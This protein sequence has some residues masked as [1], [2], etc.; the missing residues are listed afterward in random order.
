MSRVKDNKAVRI[1]IAET[2]NEC[3]AIAAENNEKFTQTVQSVTFAILQ[4]ISISLAVIADAMT[5]EPEND[6]RND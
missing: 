5:K 1:I 4:D 6:N 3:D 2:I